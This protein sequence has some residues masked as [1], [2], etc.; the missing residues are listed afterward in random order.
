MRKTVLTQTERQTL[1]EAWLHHPKAHVRNR[2]QALLLSDSGYP[3]KELANIFS[4]RTRTIYKWMNRWRDIGFAGLLILPGRGRIPVLSIN[5]EPILKVVKK[6]AVAY[7]RNLIKMAKLISEELQLK[8]TPEMLRRFLKKIG[9]TWKRFRKSLKK[10]Q[11]PEVYQKKLSEL[12]QLLE[13]YRT[14]Y[15]DLY[16]GDESGFNTEGYVP[17]GWQPKNEY[18]HITPAKTTSTQ[19]F[20]LMSL[21]NRLEAYT[22]KGSGDSKTIIACM[23]DFCD[24]IIKKTIIAL[25]NAPIHHS[26]IFQE[27][28]KQWEERDLYVF[29]LPEYSPHLNPIEILWRMMKYKWIEYENINSQDELNQI[30]EHILTNFGTEYT[31]NFKE[32]KKV[33]NIFT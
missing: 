20:G 11:N 28:I 24:R 25:D 26:L 23:D 13:L 29:F 27:K 16:F 32:H 3:V 4:V 10:K 9:Y 5:S 30:I 14:G 1:E 19:I 18:I 31:I 12:K 8:V 2:S 17:Y 21:D 33:S 7:A 15:I 6:K 22:F